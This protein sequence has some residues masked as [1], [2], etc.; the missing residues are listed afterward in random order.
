MLQNSVVNVTVRVQ[1]INDNH[2]VIVVPS[3]TAANSSDDD[4]AVGSHVCGLARRGDRLLHVVASDTDSGLNAQL[5]YALLHDATSSSSSYFSVNAD[6]GWIVALRDLSDLAVG[7]QFT[8]TVVVT[9]RGQPPLSTNSTFLLTIS[10]H[11][12]VAAAAAAGGMEDGQMRD[13]GRFTAAIISTVVILIL[14][15]VLTVVLMLMKCGRLGRQRQKLDGG[16]GGGSVVMERRWTEA[17][18]A[19]ELTAKQSLNGGVVSSEKT[20]TLYFRHPDDDA[21]VRNSSDGGTRSC[22]NIQHEFEVVW[23]AP[24]PCYL[25]QVCIFEAVFLSFIVDDRRLSRGSKTPHCAAI[26]WATRPCRMPGR[27][28]LRSDACTLYRTSTPLDHG[29]WL[30]RHRDV[31]CSTFTHLR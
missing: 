1:D 31:C 12:C 11:G 7:E 24:P 21:G 15:V 14:L 22:F 4:V 6:D 23:Q 2:P 26:P 30:D 16:V 5:R 13:A 28:T 3:S 19:E 10:E 18:G 29:P 25:R 9:D 20:S 8:L 27:H 17:D